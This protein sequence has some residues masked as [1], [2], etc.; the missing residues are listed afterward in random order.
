MN[1]IAQL[2]TRSA[3]LN[4]GQA[5]SIARRAF[6]NGP[7]T[8]VS[9]FQ[10][11]ARN[12][13]LL[14]SRAMLRNTASNV[15]R[16]QSRGI[17]TE[18]I[19]IGAAVLSAGKFIGAGAAAAGL[20]GAGTG[21][22]TVFGAL[23]SGVARNPALRGQLFSYAILGFAFAEATGLAS[24]VREAASG[25]LGE[26]VYLATIGPTMSTYRFRNIKMPEHRRI[27]YYGIGIMSMHESRF[28]GRKCPMQVRLKWIRGRIEARSCDLQKRRHTATDLTVGQR[29]SIGTLGWAS[30]T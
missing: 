8:S 1:S 2:A 11:A 5:S 30:R 29:P 16:G 19:T 15:T 26:Y 22:G 25:E 13:G 23:I 27:S 28:S 12:N 6:T 10:T 9:R 3:R 20:I 7:A 17:V 14:M 18:T 21:I 4:G 24:N